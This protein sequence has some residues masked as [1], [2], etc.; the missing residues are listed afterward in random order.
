MSEASKI[1]FLEGWGIL[2]GVPALF[3]LAFF[4]P[5]IP[6]L[7]TFETCAVRRFLHLPCPGCGLTTSFIAL[8]HLKFGE[9][10]AAHPLGIVV[11]IYLSY[12]F[13]RAIFAV[14][15]GRRPR[16]L[17]TQRQRDWV[18]GVFLVV[19]IGQWVIK[20]ARICLLRTG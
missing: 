14:V 8:T 1:R 2:L 16:E 18:L 11:A 6:I 13:A 9:C 4:Y 3:I 15:L 7:S 10:V 5:H 20:L 17:L 12:L 19:L